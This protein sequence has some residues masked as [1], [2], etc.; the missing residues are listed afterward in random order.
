MR[1]ANAT[2]NYEGDLTDFIQF[3]AIQSPLT[4]TNCRY[5]VDGSNSSVTC[6]STSRANPASPRTDDFCDSYHKHE[7]D[8]HPLNANDPTAARCTLNLGNPATSSGAFFP[9]PDQ[10]PEPDLYVGN[11]RQDAYTQAFAVLTGMIPDV[12]SWETWRRFYEH[13]NTHNNA[14]DESA[15]N[16]DNYR[17]NA[18]GHA[19][20]PLDDNTFTLTFG[21]EDHAG[22]F[23]ATGKNNVGTTGC[24]G[25]ITFTVSDNTPPSF[26]VTSNTTGKKTLQECQ[27]DHTVTGAKAAKTVKHTGNDLT[28]LD[29]R[30]TH[31][32]GPFSKWHYG[33]NQADDALHMYYHDQIRCVDNCAGLV[34][35]ANPWTNTNSNQGRVLSASFPV[36]KETIAACKQTSSGYGLF[37]T[38]GA[39]STAGND[40]TFQDAVRERTVD[41]FCRD[42]AGNENSDNGHIIHVVDTSPPLI[43]LSHLCHDNGVHNN[44]D[45]EDGS[46]DSSDRYHRHNVGSP[47]TRTNATSDP[48]G[49]F[50][51]GRIGEKTTD[52]HYRSFNSAH[53][54]DWAS[55][56]C[57]NW[58]EDIGEGTGDK[59]MVSAGY[60]QELPFLDIAF[61]RPTS[62][63][64]NNFTTGTAHIDGGWACRDTCDIF[65]NLETY[66]HWA[67]DG[68][69]PN[70]CT[71]ITAGDDHTG[72]PF[73]RECFLIPG[74]Y[75]IKYTC[76]DKSQNEALPVER[77][78][79]I[80]D[81]KIPIISVLGDTDMSLEATNEGNYVDDGATCSDQVDGMISQNVE[82]SGA[83]VNLTREGTYI[84]TY[85]CAD[86]AGY[87][88]LRKTRTVYVT[89]C[90][91][92]T[93]YMTGDNTIT[94]EASFPYVD[95][96]GWCTDDLDASPPAL[97]STSLTV[98]VEKTGVY[99]VTYFA[100]DSGGNWNYKASSECSGRE[101]AACGTYTTNNDIRTVHIVDTLKP[102][103]ALNYQ[104]N[105]FQYGDATDTGILGT[106][107][108]TNTSAGNVHNPVD[109]DQSH[110]V[111]YMAESTYTSVSGWMI[112]AIA[113]AVTGLALLGYS[114]STVATT[115]PV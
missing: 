33:D 107:G 74:T 23:G 6:V 90:N 77:T 49:D 43:A 44:D 84:I 64:P 70:A 68:N 17:W 40:D 78:V 98:N 26:S 115:V 3:N 36:F 96:Q 13:S 97:D 101:G 91:C 15:I 76:T 102:V 113:S 30:D 16:S 27:H 58:N 19:S 9:D 59:M 100:R 81:H 45:T 80:E 85:S 87:E 39:R 75:T 20:A 61:T 5:G 105:Y 22:I 62:N 47:Y 112:G 24:D 32:S 67:P 14:T 106:E 35:T 41:Y 73:P 12:G 28:S 4:T 55:D 57:V 51:E 110:R 86:S 31:T 1:Y 99:Y 72:R 93:C 71:N 95:E 52:L 65:T 109:K 83:V 103:I 92:P 53:S 56:T 37:C 29:A 38:N 2:D 69:F 111:D 34:W 114:R 60:S 21:V 89:D 50:R 25:V 10:S 66:A 63:A 7:D 48:S 18:D 108:S 79:Y 88:A 82:V 104:S 46:G 54:H 8:R 94:R 42:Y 11:M